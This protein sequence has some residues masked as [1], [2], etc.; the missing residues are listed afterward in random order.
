MSD[1]RGRSGTV[2]EEHLDLHRLEAL[3][4][5][6][7]S[8]LRVVLL[9][10]SLALVG[11]QLDVDAL[12]SVLR[13]R[14][15]M[16]P[17]TAL[18]FL[19]A[20]A[21]LWLLEAESTGSHPRK[22]MSR[23]AWIGAASVAAIGVVTIL[24][25]T[26]GQNIGLDQLLFR[27]RLSNNRIAPNTAVNFILIGGALL[28]L[29]WESRWG[30]RPAQ[31]VAL[32]PTAIALTSVLGYVYAV[33]ELY[34]IGSY[35]PM[36]LPTAIAFLALGV[37]LLCA[38]PDGGLVAA[39][40]SDHMGGALARRVLPAAAVIPAALGG[41]WLLGQR[42]GL[43]NAELG[44]AL[45]AVG[46][47]LFFL[48]LIAV[49]SRSLNRADR[50]R[51]TGERRLATQYATT[52]ILVESRTFEEAMPQ[53]LRTVGQ[54]LDWVLGA[55]WAVDGEAG[56]L[57]C[58]EMWTASAQTLEEFT[59]VNRRTTFS[60]GVGLPGRVWDTGR[61]AWI[62]DV[63]R[64][65]N[66]PR[67]PYAIRCEL[68]SA[69]GFPIVGPS[70]FLGVMEFFSHEIREPDEDLLRMFDAVG[71]QVG[72]FIERKQAESEIEQARATAEAATQAKSEFLANMSHEIRTP[73]N[74][75]IGMSTLLTGT[76]L[77]GRQREMAETIRT[78][79]E[80]LLTVINDILDFSKIESG[81]LELDEAPLDLA[82][83]V[84]E[85]VQLAAPAIK[86]TGVEL[87]YLIESNVPSTLVGD[88]GRLRQVLV[89][90]VSNAIKFTPAG[91][92]SVT[93]SSRPLADS[94]H[95][96]HFA[97]QDTGIGISPGQF[98]RLFKSFSQADASTTRRYGGT[99]LGLVIC[100]RLCELMGGRIWGESEAGRGST[101]HFT[102]EAEA[103]T[104][105]PLTRA[106]RG[107]L[108]GKRVLIVDDNRTN[109]HILKIQAERW[110]MR[111]RDTGSPSEALEW[112]QRGDP[113]DVALL[114]YQ[115]PDMDG[116]ALARELRG[117][118]GA[119]SL[120][121]I[122]LSS[123]GGVLP[124]AHAAAFEVVLSKP[125]KLSLLHDRLLEILGGP[126]EPRSV[127]NARSPEA[128]AAPLRI[129]LAED[130]A[131]N[132][133]VA[134][135]LLERLEHRA[136]VAANGHEVLDQLE[137]VPYDV[138]LMDVQMPGMD[139]LEASRAVCARW[140]SDRRPRIIAMTAE[141]MEGDRERCLAAGMDDYLAKPI[142]LDE[143]QRAL[144]QCRPVATHHV[145]SEAPAPTP[146]GLDHG[147]LDGLRE[148]LDN[149]ET[150]R[151]VVTVFLDR[152][153]LAI[154]ELRD[155]AARGDQ[156]ALGA[157]AHSLKGTSATLGALALSNECAELERLA[158]AGRL[159]EVPARLEA[160]ATEA[161]VASR[162]LRR[163]IGDPSP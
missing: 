81:K 96:V 49:A 61:A 110:G 101:F 39:I 4:S 36:A 62:P 76:V 146:D 126:D 7:R 154:A 42:A 87:T 45:L 23:A 20:A 127:G 142:R 139:G 3:R 24:G 113:C 140:P 53:I 71:G 158:R 10:G 18:G 31:L 55:R 51:Q 32:L 163:E 50:R 79:G 85:A 134:L 80:H 153:P 150:L 30:P 152:T 68:H 111:A 64:D 8:L 112:I 161:E 107:S 104:V 78:S 65:P 129:L 86:D 133:T 9:I 128:P 29:G 156:A 28:L 13:G 132:Q 74:A 149:V 56:V 117:A 108:A 93:V 160:I 77:D 5:L 148:D 90:L 14:V 91:E 115:M 94:R 137:R 12:K 75:I 151:Q 35:I 48:G 33:G 143:L 109:R 98:D 38:R 41:L 119:E 103:V 47:I 145:G 63:T 57:Q 26:L 125:V 59:G 141:A 136:D 106:D 144:S 27:A 118:R 138:I 22:W 120:A 2:G 135:R 97:V 43:F 100:R 17:L 83:C 25:Y 21:S 40:A 122:L 88:A 44:L 67:A 82:R 147:V 162:A 84:E 19:L 121:L 102:I 70:G 15:A 157:G 95:E 114:D 46:N 105:L 69:F 131:I 54:S 16:N 11:W 116:F 159:Q 92:I 34:A 89:N 52:R 155:A 123:I 124:P 73:L 72:Q 6:S 99:G 58:A 60:R 37:A 130:N 66:F 1:E